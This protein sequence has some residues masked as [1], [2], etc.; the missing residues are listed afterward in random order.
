MFRRLSQIYRIKVPDRNQ[1][2]NVS[3]PEQNARIIARQLQSVRQPVPALPTN[4]YIESEASG[5]TIRCA[6][7]LWSVNWTRT[8][9]SYWNT[10]RANEEGGWRILILQYHT[11]TI[12]IHVWAFLLLE[13]KYETCRYSDII[14]FGL[15]NIFQGLHAQKSRTIVRVIGVLRAS[16]INCC[17]PWK[18]ETF[19]S[20]HC[21]DYSQP[22]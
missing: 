18:G 11:L 9:K 19:V 2:R 6:S 22:R 13:T 16:P 3:R 14:A 10:V 17:Q 12:Q 5:P 1:W 20:R 7:C 4:H 15:V 21:H 8:G